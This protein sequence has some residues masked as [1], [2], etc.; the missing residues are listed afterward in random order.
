MFDMKV[1]GFVDLTKN[2]FKI[3]KVSNNVY[4]R[5][6]KDSLFKTNK[7]L[8]LRNYQSC[9]YLLFIVKNKRDEKKPIIVKLFT[10]GI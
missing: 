1:T 2:Y 3:L 6:Y 8:T 4:K 5:K 9:K 10:E 7:I